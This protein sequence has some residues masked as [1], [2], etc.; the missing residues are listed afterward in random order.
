M[1]L[2]RHSCDDPF[3]CQHNWPEDCFVQCG[4]SE[5]YARPNGMRFFFEAFP[6]NPNTF[7]RADSAI[8]IADAEN[9]AFA[10]HQNHLSC[11]LDHANPVNFERRN[12]KNGLGFC[13]NCG[14]SVSEIFQPLEK[15]CQCEKNTYYTQDNTGKWW[16]EKCWENVPDSLLTEF[17]K[18]NK[19][20]L[21]KPPL[22]DT[23]I[24][25]GIAAVFDHILGITLDSKNNT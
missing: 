6:R 1:K 4:G 3:P 9:K 25:E 22:T 13:I 8:S 23:E 20:S 12:Y 21:I 10:K 24:Q 5:K 16:C 15:C 18:Y 2:A 19:E 17:Q 14:M 11:K 7:I